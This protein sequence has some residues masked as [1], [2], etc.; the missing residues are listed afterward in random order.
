MFQ[1]IVTSAGL[2]LLL[3]LSGFFVFFS[4]LPLVLTARRRGLLP[5]LVSFAV[6]LILLFLL[7]RLP[8]TPLPFLPLA[9]LSSRFGSDGVTVLSLL[10]FF[11]Y[12]WLGLTLS[13][14]STRGGSLEQNLLIV[15]V[16]VSVVPVLLLLGFA[17]GMGLD[18]PMEFRAALQD[19]IGQ[20]LTLQEKSGLR[21]DELQI[22]RQYAVI[23]VGRMVE[24]LPALFVNMTLLVTSLNILFLRRWI[25][26]ERFFP[27]WP[28]FALWRL[29][30]FWIWLPIAFGALFFANL[31]LIHSL[32]IGTVV[33][34]LLLVLA[35][36]YFFQ[37][38]AILSWVFRRKF[39]P[40]LRIACTLLILLFLQM[41]GIVIV[42]VGLFDFWF[43][44]RKLKRVA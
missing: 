27:G 19:L 22:L 9:G 4:P 37:G 3:Y 43:D 29:H 14:V 32:P 42:V 28:E 11:F 7:Y 6:A 33:L 24:V 31:Y 23:L 8:Q 2:S 44:F 39:P 35:A 40:L 38:L 10:Y 26:T 20:M 17:K 16:S 12:G 21:G 15:L 13:V 36:V 18:L 1:S 34:N 25:G 30:E 41:V 5:M